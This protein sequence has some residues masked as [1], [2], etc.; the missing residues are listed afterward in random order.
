MAEIGVPVFAVFLHSF[1]EKISESEVFGGDD[2]VKTLK[3]VNFVFFD[4][5]KEV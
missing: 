5:L 3:S 4:S 2:F 1:F